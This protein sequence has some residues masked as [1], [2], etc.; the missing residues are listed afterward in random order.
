VTG[1]I[2]NWQIYFA[3]WKIADCLKIN[4]FRTFI[5]HF[6]YLKFIRQFPLIVSQYSDASDQRRKRDVHLTSVYSL[7]DQRFFQNSY[8]TSKP[9]NLFTSRDVETPAAC[10]VRLLSILQTNPNK[11]HGLQNTEI[12]M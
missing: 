7:C 8:P 12:T 3:D 2:F 1:V 5:F 11:G 6:S 10:K 9:F 4:Q